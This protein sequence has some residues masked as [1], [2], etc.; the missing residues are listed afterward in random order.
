MRLKGCAL[1]SVLV[2]LAPWWARAADPA[3]VA[4]L[5]AGLSAQGGEAR[6]RA[7]R[8][9]RVEI[10]GYR[11]LLEQSERPQGPYIPELL[12]GSEIHDQ[13]HGRFR[14]ETTDA[15]YPN[16]EGSEGATAVTVVADGIAMRGAGASATPG[17]GLQVR[18][19]AERLALSPE[20]LMI[21]ALDA[22]DLRLEPPVEMQGLGQDV[23]SFRLDGAPVRLFLN[24]FTHLP[25]AFDYSGP[26]ARTGFFAYTGDATRRTYL[27][28]WTL[29]DQGVRLPLQS[30]IVV[31]GLP[32]RTLV[33]SKLAVDA[34]LPQD[35]FAIPPAV[36]AAFRPGPP[37]RT[38]ETIPLGSPAAPAQ[39]LAPGVV[40]IPGLWNVTL[41][42]QD[43]GVVVLDAPISSGYSAQVLAEA[44]RRFPGLRV[45]AVVSTSDA[46]PHIAGLREGRGRQDAA[47]LR[48]QSAGALSRARGD[49]RAPG[50]GLFPRAPTALRQRRIPAR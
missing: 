38:L 46:W 18:I 14:E 7:L 36:K 23:V 39:E 28:L 6:L 13:Q 35:A 19:A 12:T 49:Q 42:R 11:N 43:D 33:V 37:A 45:K 34:A 48:P 29:T 9:L 17:D 2:C 10:I 8:T 41:V 3:A 5:R 40:F 21:T 30:D 32:D 1:I 44:A 25:T 26:W 16:G 22:P 24:R 47:G 20:R 27:S 15:V 31:N 50:H 4:V